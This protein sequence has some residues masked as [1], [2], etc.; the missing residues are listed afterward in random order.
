MEDI[1]KK[2][3]SR[4]VSVAPMAG[5]T[6][7]VLRNLIREYSKTCLIATEMISSE[8][9]N[10][11]HDCAII[12][13]SESDSPIAYQIS[14]HKPEL[15]AKA[16]KFLESRTDIIDINMGCPVKKVTCGGDGSALMKPPELAQDIVKTVKKS[17]NVPVSVKFRLGFTADTM[18]YVEFGQMMQEAGADFITIHARTR[19]QMY[20]GNADWSKIKALKH[21][22]DIPVFANGDIVSV[23]TAEQCL[24]LSDADGVAIGRG[25]LGDVSLPYRI[26]HYFQTGERLPIPSIDEKLDILT[27]HLENEISLRGIDVG[28]KCI[29]KLYGYYISGIRNAAKYR[30]ELV[31]IDDYSQMLKA[32]ERIRFEVH[33]TALSE[34]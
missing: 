28:I 12:K 19:A 6:D 22:V 30:A 26:E 10:H 13:K 31:R 23:D 14:G 7:L 29:R 16:A 15:M 34:V 9:L 11:V 3:I 4:K 20:S 25:V 8:G 5:I 32:L 1:I 18:N 2:I 33:Q 17:V 27:R 21:S 24:E